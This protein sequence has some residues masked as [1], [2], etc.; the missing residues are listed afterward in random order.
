MCNVARKAETQIEMHAN[1]LRT[2]PSHPS[3]HPTP[4]LSSSGLLCKPHG[5]P[6]R[7]SRHSPATQQAVFRSLDVGMSLSDVAAAWALACQDTVC[8]ESCRR[9]GIDTS[10]GRIVPLHGGRGRR[11]SGAAGGRHYYCCCDFVRFRRLI[12]VVPSSVP[13]WCVRL[14]AGFFCCW[15]YVLSSSQAVTLIVQC[16]EGRR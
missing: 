9:V 5:P 3:P 12:F 1:L 8:W 11:S 2:S 15:C 16:A 10:I 7:V 14:L 4:G 13:T 6:P